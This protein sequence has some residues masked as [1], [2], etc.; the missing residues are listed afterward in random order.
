MFASKPGKGPELVLKKSWHFYT[1]MIEAGTWNFLK[2]IEFYKVLVKPVP[3]LN[4]F[5]R[6]PSSISSGHC[7]KQRQGYNKL[8]NS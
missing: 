4:C 1:S 2:S 5:E 7:I 3:K 8:E 6:C